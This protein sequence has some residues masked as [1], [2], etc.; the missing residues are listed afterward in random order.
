MNE[1][2]FNVSRFQRSIRI[3]TDYEDLSIIDSFVSS[4]TANKSIVQVCNHINNGQ[5]AFT[6]TGA[7]GSGKSSLAL[8]LHGGLSH[9]NTQI[10]KKSLS[11]VSE[12]AKNSIENTFSKFSKRIVLP[13]VA[14]KKDLEKVI[15][16]QLEKNKIKNPKKK[17]LINLLDEVSKEYQVIIFV[18]ELGKY[19]EFASSNNT[20]IMFLQNL[21]EICD[22]SNGSIIFIGILHQSFSE[23]SKSSDQSIREEWAKIQGRFTDIPINVSSEEHVNLMSYSLAYEPKKWSDADHNKSIFDFQN[24]LKKEHGWISKDNISKLYP[25]N[26]ISAFLISAI[27]KR[28]F[29]QNQRT[30]FGFL[31]SIEPHGFKKEYLSNK[32]NSNFNYSPCDLWDYL[33]SNLDSSIVNSSDGHNW[34]AA[35][36]CVERGENNLEL[37]S[38]EVLK[39]IALIQIFGSRTLVK[40]NIDNIYTAFPYANHDIIDKAINELLQKKF[41]LYREA[42]KTFSISEAS[43][44][45]VEQKLK[46]YLS[47]TDNLDSNALEKIVEFRPIIAKRHYTETG[48]FRYMSINI[49]SLEDVQSF[50][51]NPKINCDGQILICLP[52]NNEKL[53]QIK[54]VA[55]KLLKRVQIPLAIAIPKQSSQIIKLIK[56]LWALEKIEQQE[57]V[58]KID[59]VARKEIASFIDIDK[60]ELENLVSNVLLNSDWIVSKYNLSNINNWEDITSNQQ[61]KLNSKVSELFDE[62]YHLAPKIKNE[63]TNKTKPSPNANQAI[64]KLMYRTL[65]H[66]NYQQLGIEKTPPELTIYRSIIKDHFHRKIS[67]KQY[68]FGSPE[69]NSQ[70][71]YYMWK[72][73]KKLIENS[74]S[75]VNAEEIFSLWSKPPFGI[76]RGTFPIILM[77]FI[78]TNR[79]SLAMFH[80]E[81]FVTDFDEITVEGLIKFAKDFSFTLVNFD[82]DG[83]RLHKYFKVLSK[84]SYQNINPVI[85]ELP[86][87]IGRSLVKILKSQPELVYATQNLSPKS[88]NLRDEVKKANDPIDLVLKVLPKIFDDNYKEFE[89][90][91][92]EIVNY[93]DDAIIQF[94]DSIFESFNCINSEDGLKEI[95]TRAS[96]ILKKSGNLSLDPFVYQIEAFDGSKTSTEDLLFTLL[97]KDPKKINDNDIKRIPIE[98]SLSVDNFLKVEAHTKISKRK[99]KTSAMSILY[100]GAENKNILNYDFKLNSKEIKK[101]KEIAENLEDL[102]LKSFGKNNKLSKENKQN[103]ILGAFSEFFNKAKQEEE[104]AN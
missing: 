102:V 65:S 77:M 49:K 14:G 92:S 45:D 54:D 13:L 35:S 6:W 96:Q 98:L 73:A 36:E 29:A 3:D 15:L 95:N 38:L 74:T 100:G 87:N 43:D 27:S 20:D 67:K 99:Y 91:I 103:I 37:F 17:D 53:K 40:N 62:F 55:S 69:K 66:E 72:E 83:E 71:F 42:L 2:S 44:F 56:R 32:N 84:Y 81:I 104:N 90:S 93:Y 70:E 52:F 50:I 16:E 23:Y 97:K 76:K 79:N 88:L 41:I 94:R 89:K 28:S 31:N 47:N 33:F 58:I 19:L 64:R 80:E 7:Y 61:H 1:M 57:E 39:T 8:I 25:L 86:L 46:S 85:H 101:A 59:K 34:L 11:L 9:K 63:L 60:K 48:N 24:S 51:E 26:P 22:R 10:Y 75:Y 4:E 12:E 30:I 18:D 68:V 78:L 5:Q 82:D 21:A